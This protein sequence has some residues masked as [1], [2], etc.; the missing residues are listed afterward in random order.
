[1]KNVTSQNSMANRKGPFYGYMKA[2]QEVHEKY[3]ITIYNF[4]NFAP[5]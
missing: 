5:K 3:V 1:M 4:K 2:P